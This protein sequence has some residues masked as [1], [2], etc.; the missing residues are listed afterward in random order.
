VSRIGYEEG[1][2]MDSAIKTAPEHE[3]ELI[4]KLI[5]TS[6]AFT[7]YFDH[8][9]LLNILDDLSIDSTSIRDIRIFLSLRILSSGDEQVIINGMKGLRNFIIIIRR[10]LLPMIKEKF[11][12]SPFSQD[13]L[14]MDK[15]Q[16]ILRAFT[17][18]A[19]PVNLDKI[20]AL[21]MELEGIL[22]KHRIYDLALAV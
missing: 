6:R 14:L 9:W 21:T 17:A 20:T 13:R 4:R 1:K 19:L 5:E 7:D 15:S 16:Y 10:H 2:M 22:Q 12:V 8:P 11:G 3:N 18:Y